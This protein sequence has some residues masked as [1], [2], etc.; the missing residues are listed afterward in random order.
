MTKEKWE[1]RN[2]TEVV[3]STALDIFGDKEN[4]A[5]GECLPAMAKLMEEW[6]WGTRLSELPK[7][8]I[9]RLIITII[10]EFEKRMKEDQPPGEQIPLF[11]DV[12]VKVP[13]PDDD[14]D[15]ASDA[16][17]EAEKKKIEQSRMANALI[18]EGMILPPAIRKG[19]VTDDDFPWETPEPADDDLF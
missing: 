12:K 13:I 5:L 8:K 4:R 10:L 3:Y 2:G 15:R 19:P 18:P 14:V 17:H 11:F 9:K 1:F 6:G 16:I 7:D